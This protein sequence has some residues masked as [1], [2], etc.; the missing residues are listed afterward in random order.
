MSEAPVG[1][2]RPAS[3]AEAPPEVR[4]GQGAEPT[5]GSGQTAADDAG[6]GQPG[7][8]GDTD[9]GAAADRLARP[10]LAPLVD[11]LFRRFGDGDDPVTLVVRNPPT[12][13]REALADLFGLDRLPPPDPRI[14]ISRLVEVLGVGSV[15]SLRDVVESLRGPLPD[16]RTDRLADRAARDGLWSWLA[17]EAAVLTSLGGRPGWDAAWVD[18]MRAQGARG[19]V[20]AHRGRLEAALR[21]LRALPADGVPLAGFANDHLGDPHALDRGHRLPAIVLDAVALAGEAPLATGAES[22]RHLWESVGVAPDPLSSTVLALGL[23]GDG[24]PAPLGAWLSAARAAGEPVVLT[25]AQLRRWPIA[26]LASGVTAYVVENPSLVAEA[27]R[28]GWSGPPLVCSSGRPTVAVVTLVRRLAAAGGTVRQHADFDAAGVA[29]T[30]WLAERAGTTPWRM[31]AGDYLSA[32]AGRHEDGSPPV[33]LPP[34]PWDPPLRTAMLD[35]GIRVYE[36]E[37]RADL[38]AAMV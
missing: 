13:A 26:P 14:R 2:G 21:M 37:F 33:V 5:R 25:L 10:E 8:D 12:A 23:S 36:E 16:R 35:T 18:R 31:T 34:T 24:S 1:G 15:R 29:I 28:T 4:P 3:A 32:A 19:G 7:V 20:D 9:A 11:E 22:A 27:A 17:A 6:G 38:L 30:A